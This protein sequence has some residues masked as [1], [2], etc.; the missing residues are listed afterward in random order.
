M[1]KKNTDEVVTGMLSTAIARGASART[2]AHAVAPE[3]AA[4]PAAERTTVDP[5]APRTWRLRPTTAAQLREAWLEAKRDDV[6]LTAQDFAS[7]LVDE[8][9][10]HRRSRP[11]SIFA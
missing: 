3:T 7:T 9:L 6:L 5:D 10:E 4:S 11:G 1:P 2:G 8:A